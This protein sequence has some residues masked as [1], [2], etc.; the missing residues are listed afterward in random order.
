MLSN[1]RLPTADDI[2]G[3]TFYWC[4]FGVDSSS[5]IGQN[6]YS[7]DWFEYLYLVVFVFVH[8]PVNASWHPT[9]RDCSGDVLARTAIFNIIGY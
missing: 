6:G 3:N 9:R 8:V 7:S 2:K 4:L 1:G 5:I